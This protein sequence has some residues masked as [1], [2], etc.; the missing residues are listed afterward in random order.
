VLL[1]IRHRDVLLRVGI[2]VVTAV[3]VFFA[4]G[5]WQSPF[6]Y[7]TGWTPPRNLTART[8]FEMVDRVAT[9]DAREKARREVIPLYINDPRQ[10]EQLQNALIDKVLQVTKS[11]DYG[12]VDQSV[13]KDFFNDTPESPASDEVKQASFTQFRDVFANKDGAESANVAVLRKALAVALQEHEE[14]GLLDNLEHELGEGSQ[15]LLDTYQVGQNPADAKLL[16]VSE[17]RIGEVGDRLEQKLAAE[18]ATLTMTAHERDSI[19]KRLFVWL[20]RHLPKTLNYDREATEKRRISVVAEVNNVMRTYA[21]GEPLTGIEQGQP[22][23]TADL[24]LLRREHEATLLAQ[25]WTHAA[26]HSLAKFGMYAALYLLCGV[27]VYHHKRLLITDLR[28]FVTLLAFLTITV[29]LAWQGARDQW[30]M[31]LIP[32]VIFAITI[33]I[34]YRQD[35]AL[36]LSASVALITVTSLGLGLGELVIYVSAVAASIVLS[37]RIR[38]RTRLIFAGLWAS[39]VTLATA[40]GVQILVGQPFG[41][42]LLLNAAWV[43]GCALVASIL[44]TGLLPFFEKILDFQTDLSLLELGDQSHKLLKMLVQKAP[45]TYNHSI[46][47]ASIG[48]AAAESIGA[49]GLLVRVGAYFHDIGKM[50]KPGYFVENQSEGINRHD[51]LAPAM[52]TLVIIAHVKDGVELARQHGLPEIIIDFIEQHHGTTL[53]EYFYVQASRASEADPD[54]AQIDETAFRYPGPKPQT[55]E[56]AVMMLTDAVESACR[57]LTDPGP[58]RIESLVKDIAMKRLLDEQFDE[59]ALTLDEL[60]IVQQSLIKSLTAVYHGRVKYPAKQQ[61]A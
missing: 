32:I 24:L 19:A 35:V 18:L 55:K 61:S 46:N 37:Q 10:L 15:T 59:C 38:T 14:H 3:A 21:A 33:S 6:A 41:P 44:M 22:L 26:A 42:P 47:V 40:I 7:R 43:A 53:V 54:A 25:P 45:G 17:V 60:S 36:L 12:D 30:R 1:R 11:E 13:W 27:F 16:P 58:A 29:A 9:Q 4:T 39:L 31:E 50:L 2:C 52:S 48:E 56:A 28:R 8:T 51:T 57:T 5:A 49:N 20:R 34:A 23:S